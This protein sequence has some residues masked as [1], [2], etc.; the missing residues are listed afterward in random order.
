MTCLVQSS[1]VNEPFSDPGLFIDF[2]FGRRALLFDLGDLTPLSPR[3]LL[4]PARHARFLLGL[5]V[6]AT[7]AAAV[8]RSLGVADAERRKREVRAQLYF[9]RTKVIIPSTVTI[10]AMIL[11]KWPS[12]RNDGVTA[13]SPPLNARSRDR[14]S[15]RK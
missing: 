14:L 15:E 5:S 9:E 4:R 8:G 10:G 2:R 12:D 13:P 1:L 11:A 6:A 7:L 3:H